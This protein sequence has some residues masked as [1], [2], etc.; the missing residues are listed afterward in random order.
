MQDNCISNT[1]GGSSQPSDCG[2]QK[3]TVMFSLLSIQQ[4]LKNL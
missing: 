4:K 3:P 1:E 2:L